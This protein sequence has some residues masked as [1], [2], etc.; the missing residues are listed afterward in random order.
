MKNWECPECGRTNSGS[1][2]LCVC[3]YLDDDGVHKETLVAPIH[4]SQ[5]IQ[6][7]IAPKVKSSLGE[8]KPRPI[9]LWTSISESWFQLSTW[10]AGYTRW[11]VLLLIGISYCRGTTD[12]LWFIALVAIAF[13]YRLE[14]HKRYGDPFVA[15]KRKDQSIWDYG[16][17]RTIVAIIR[18]RCVF[19]GS[20]RGE[21]YA[22][23]RVLQ[24]AIILH[25]YLALIIL[26][27]SIN[28]DFTT[29]ILTVFNQPFMPLLQYWPS[30]QETADKLIAHGYT[31]RV[32]IISHAYLGVAIGS[33][34]HGLYWM[35]FLF[36]LQ[37]LE[38]Y[39]DS[40][41]AIYKT[42]PPERP[43]FSPV[44]I[45]HRPMTWLPWRWTV[46]LLG[47]GACIFFIWYACKLP[48]YFP[49]EPHLRR[50]G[51]YIWLYSYAYNDN[52]GIFTPVY[53]VLLGCMMLYP[54][55]TMLFEPFFRSGLYLIRLV[56]HS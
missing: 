7:N 1:I 51:K 44:K 24:I 34:I 56:K 27:D 55:I 12:G 29:H 10:Q 45:S 17:G 11:M 4:S 46:C 3:G 6:E 2:I 50:G 21:A 35:R 9:L 53:Q 31:N 37:S 42:A 33:L 28:S 30:W 38:E 8:I 54:C 43:L 40:K 13:A 19:E 48:L 36:K 15:G 52:I 39:Y 16:L 23:G 22:S 26:S 47:C 5:Q 18:P 49:G 32:P 25:L 20:I 41:V 14:L